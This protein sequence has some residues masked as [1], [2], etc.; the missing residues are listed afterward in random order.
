MITKL[1]K[2]VVASD[3][4]GTLVQASGNERFISYLETQGIACN[5]AL[6]KTTG[7]W[8][9]ATGMNNAQL[10]VYYSEFQFSA[11]Y[12]PPDPM[13]GAQAAIQSLRQDFTLNIVTARSEEGSDITRQEQQKHFG[14]AFSL[15]LFGAEGKKAD[16]VKQV[17]AFVFMEDSIDHA[18][19]VV[20]VAFV[21]LIPTPPKNGQHIDPRLIRPQAR[22]LVVDG[23]SSDDWQEVWLQTWQ[24]IPHL[25]RDLHT[26]QT[27]TQVLVL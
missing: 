1:A 26:K 15:T 22:K 14:S 13:P 11:A 9:A 17:G 2:Q 24:E 4:D 19:Q 12:Q 6:F 10:G 3:F 21:I 5:K 25:I 16:K 18:T 23:M 20:E 8:H 7:S 27:Q